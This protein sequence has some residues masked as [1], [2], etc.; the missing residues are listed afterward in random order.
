MHYAIHDS[1]LQDSIV[2]K[3]VSILSAKK[4]EILEE[5]CILCGNHQCFVFYSEPKLELMLVLIIQR[6]ELS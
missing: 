2:S 5:K 1:V 3:T 6:R 4:L